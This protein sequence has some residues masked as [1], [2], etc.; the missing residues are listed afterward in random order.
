MEKQ[1]QPV[2]KLNFI[3]LYSHTKY[4]MKS[5]GSNFFM[6]QVIVPSNISTT[7]CD[8][9]IATLRTGLRAQA[10]T[11]ERGARREMANL[12]QC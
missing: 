5:H 9:S 8:P 10:R 3:A 7:T 1:L 6:A 12:S 2:I 11:G 4:P